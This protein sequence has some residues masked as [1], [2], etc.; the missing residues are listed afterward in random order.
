[1]AGATFYGGVESAT[2]GE[3][4]LELRFRVEAAAAL[5]VSRDLPLCFADRA[6]ADAARAGLRRVGVKTT[7]I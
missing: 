3:T 4:S 7:G 2:L 5:G 6:D 1:V